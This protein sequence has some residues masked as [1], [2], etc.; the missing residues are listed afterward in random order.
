VPPVARSPSDR[1]PLRSTARSV[2]GGTASR[3]EAVPILADLLARGGLLQ[4]AKLRDLKL[5]AVAALTQI[6]G[7]SADD[8]LARAAKGADGAVRQAAAVAQK[9]RARG[10]GAAA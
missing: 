5:A 7:R 8:A 3:A 9:R 1:S 6:P 4:R 10:P 2:R